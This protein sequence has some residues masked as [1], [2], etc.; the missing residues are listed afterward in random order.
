LSLLLSLHGVTL[1]YPGIDRPIVKELDLEVHRGERVL[2]AGP[3]GCGKSTLLLL[4]AG[5]IPELIPGDISGTFRRNTDNLAIVLQNPEAQMI[6]PTIEEELAFGMENQGI[7]PKLIRS[8]VSELLERFGLSTYRHES[9][10]AL[11]GGER[12]K[13][14]LASALALDPELL[15]LDEPTAY[16]DPEST[17]SFFDLLQTIDP[18]TA[19]VI[20]EHKLEHLQHFI[21][22]Y[23]RLDLEGR[24][25][26]A[27]MD[28]FQEEDFLPWKLVRLQDDTQTADSVHQRSAERK[29]RVIQVKGL[30]HRYGEK[31]V[32]KE[33]CADLYRRET[34]TVMGSNGAGKTT[35][36]EKLAGLLPNAPGTI[37]IDGDDLT[38]LSSPEL[39]ARLLL[40]PQNPEHFFLRESTSGELKLAS[41]DD[42]ARALTR[43]RLEERLMELNPFQLSEGEK[44]RLNLACAFM[45]DRPILL[46]DEPAYGLD[47]YAYE[48]LVYSL[49]ELKQKKLSVLMATH[50]PELAFLVSDRILLMDRGKIVLK[51]TP[52]ELTA[53]VDLPPLYQ[54]IW[55]RFRRDIH[56]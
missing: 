6:A 27:S 52:A 14:S 45:D 39:Y 54:P 25:S 21:D 48:A 17:A 44:R 12:Q 49:R 55:E 19:I 28:S 33:L 16:L 51:G 5:V 24:A 42:S 7:A 4:M 8:K 22:R 1:R 32:L 56:V 11:S 30:S 31:E 18:N 35:L 2:L 34:V 38:G 15:L 43:F 23:Y 9:P 41:A 46:I 40:L 20:V 53:G 37:R 13:V 10:S 3:S 47:Y 36:L 29:E 50:S 26:S